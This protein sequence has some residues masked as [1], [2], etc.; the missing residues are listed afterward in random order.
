MHSPTTN[1]VSLTT[2]QKQLLDTELAAVSSEVYALLQAGRHDSC[3]LSNLLFSMEYNGIFWR[4]GKDK[5]Q[6][7]RRYISQSSL[8]RESQSRSTDL[9][10][11]ERGYRN[12]TT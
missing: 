4:L 10:Y 2:E 9:M 3:T 12:T 11:K 6:E 5:T 1:E 8:F 7:E